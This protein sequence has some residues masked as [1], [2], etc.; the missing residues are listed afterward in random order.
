[1]HLTFSHITAAILEGRRPGN[2]LDIR[3]KERGCFVSK[4]E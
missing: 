1:M 3:I 4:V 2:A